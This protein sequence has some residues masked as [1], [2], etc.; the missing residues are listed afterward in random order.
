MLL[1]RLKPK[2]EY[3]EALRESVLS[4]DAMKRR[5]RRGQ[6]SE[7]EAVGDHQD[8]VAGRFV[9][10]VRRRVPSHRL[11]GLGCIGLAQR[12]G[13]PRH[14]HQPEA[15]DLERRPGKD[16]QDGHRNKVADEWASSRRGGLG[17]S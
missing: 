10:E 8:E 6:V 5:S 2:S 11:L 15:D 14:A 12:H 9:R 3:L 7:A 13:A 4:V 16:R 17:A 1:D